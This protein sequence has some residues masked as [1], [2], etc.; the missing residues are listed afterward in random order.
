MAAAKEKRKE[1]EKGNA[2]EDVVLI[3]GT[4]Q[5][6][7]NLY[8]LD[9][10]GFNLYSTS[11]FIVDQCP[12]SPHLVKVSWVNSSS[13]YMIHGRFVFEVVYC[14]QMS[15]SSNNLTNVCF[16]EGP[17]RPMSALMKVSFDEGPLR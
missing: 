14:Q 7:S 16:D 1:K 5:N 10:Y 12:L 6:L 13:L 9:I 8:S 2:L 11:L 4:Q 17:L 15:A 3:A